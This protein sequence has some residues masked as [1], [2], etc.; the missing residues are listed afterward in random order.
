MGFEQ[1]ISGG[2][3]PG[4]SQV[5]LSTSTGVTKESVITSTSYQVLRFLA[6]TTARGERAALVTIT[7]LTGSSSRPVST[8]MGISETGAFAGSFSGGCIE[9]AVVAEAQEAIR[10]GKR[11]KVRYGA[12]SHY[13]D[14]RLPCGGGV[15]LLFLPDPVSDVIRR[16]CE[17][18]DQRLPL[19]LVQYG[20]GEIE[21][22]P[23]A[24]K[25]AP[26]W[27][28]DIFTSWYPPSLKIVV[29][30]H[31]AESLALVQLGVTFGADMLLLSPDERLV[32]QAQASG[33]QAGLITAGS[34]PLI[35]MDPWCAAVFLFHDHAW[36]LA[37]MA[38][39]L[40]QPAFFIGAMGSRKTHE[41][42]LRKLREIGV[43]D[44]N[45]PRIVAPLGLIPSARDPLTLG[46]SALAQVAD[47]Y[48]LA[49]SLPLEAGHLTHPVQSV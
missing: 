31:G 39:A 13:L 17:V 37:L 29:V 1:A 20:S 44:D 40:A 34:T 22:I 30:G 11:R 21:I 3:L 38:Q 41:N 47:Q 14:I 18:M 7:G 12:G 24:P 5:D 4:I 10:D 8:L 49:T 48:R 25:S 27:S 46:L 28:G 15:D 6:E 35:A 9:A 2:P 23:D 42:R 19:S 16:A 26:G 36:E 33:A 43:C 45:L 32:E